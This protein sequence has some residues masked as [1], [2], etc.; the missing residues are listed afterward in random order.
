MHHWRIAI[1]LRAD[2]GLVG[3]WRFDQIE[4]LGINNDGPDDVRDLSVLHNHLDLMNDAHLV[5]FIP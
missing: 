2:S 1:L 5:P 3:Y 4:D